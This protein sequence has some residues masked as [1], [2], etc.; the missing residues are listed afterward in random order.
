MADLN[1]IRRVYQLLETNADGAVT[2]HEICRFT[3]KLGIVMAEEDLRLMVRNKG[4]DDCSDS[5]QFEE[6]VELYHFIFNC[7]QDKD[8]YESEDLM[9]AFKIFDENKD[10]YISCEELQRVLSR[11]E[12][13]PHSQ[14]PQECE[15]MICRFDSD[16]NGVLDFSEFKCMMSATVSMISL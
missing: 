12:L 2:V 16:C 13:I 9:E 1:E 14:Q 6:F 10:G 4:A 11:L 7:E 5:L 8:I 15:K 3:N